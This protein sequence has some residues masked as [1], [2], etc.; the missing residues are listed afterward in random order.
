MDKPIS[1]LKVQK[2]NPNRVNVY[3][4]GEYAFGVSRIVA[5]WLQVGQLLDDEKIRELKEKD[6]H[7]V[8]LGEA[9]RFIGYRSRTEAEVRH[10]LT[11]K[12]FSEIEI[13]EVIERLRTDGLLQDRQ[14]A[15][16]WVESRTIFRPRSHRLMAIE[17]HQKGIGEEEIQD[18]LL[19]A[20]DDSTLAYEAA[21][22]YSR[23]L[24]DL[25]WDKFRERLSAYLMRRGFVYGTITEIVRRVWTEIR[26]P[27]SED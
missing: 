9:L 10:K 1:A 26:M 22:R 2:R 25:E 17:L 4:D 13:A 14:F 3:L 19:T 7:E 23:R 12:G 24:A 18:A 16:A 11:E 5:A 6:V 15:H 27:E 20:V 8:A 21:R